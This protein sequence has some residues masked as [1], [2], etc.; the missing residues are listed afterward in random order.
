M[1][2]MNRLILCKK[3]KGFVAKV[4][5]EITILEYTQSKIGKESNNFLNT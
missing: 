1:K 3:N 5:W 2:S 4:V